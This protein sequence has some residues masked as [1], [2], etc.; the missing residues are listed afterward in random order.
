MDFA[1]PLKIEL[2]SYFSRPQN[3]TSQGMHRKN[4]K[5]ATIYCIARYLHGATSA[6]ACNLS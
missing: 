1:P 3:L 6:D 2:H 5:L 4:L